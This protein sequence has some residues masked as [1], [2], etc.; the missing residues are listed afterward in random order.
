VKFNQQVSTPVGNGIAIAK[1]CLCDT[2]CTDSDMCPSTTYLI[3]FKA[4]EY[5]GENEI[6]GK[7]VIE[8]VDLSNVLGE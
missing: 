7:V 2:M 8:E 6:N 5:K 3:S 4:S 1:V